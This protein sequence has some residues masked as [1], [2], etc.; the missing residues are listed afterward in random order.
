MLT[1][2]VPVSM[3]P[4]PL[5]RG[6]HDPRGRP[7][8]P[9][10]KT[11]AK[12]TQAPLRTG[13]SKKRLKKLRYCRQRSRKKEDMFHLRRL[14]SGFFFEAV[15]LPLD[16]A[17]FACYVSLL[18]SQ[19]GK[20]SLHSSI[21]EVDDRNID[22]VAFQKA[23]SIDQRLFKKQALVSGHTSSSDIT[24]SDAPSISARTDSTVSSDFSGLPVLPPIR[25][26][27]SPI[28]DVSRETT[29]QLFILP[30][31]SKG[32]AS[33]DVP[34]VNIQPATPQHSTLTASALS[35]HHPTPTADRNE[36][37]LADIH[38][39]LPPV[40]IAKLD[41]AKSKTSRKINKKDALADSLNSG[42]LFQPPPLLKP[43]HAHL[44]AAHFEN[45]HFG[46]YPGHPS[47]SSF[48]DSLDVNSR[49]HWLMMAG[50]QSESLKGS[51]VMAPDGEIVSVGGS[52]VRGGVQG[53][54][55]A[56][57]NDVLLSYR[58]EGVDE[59][60]VSVDETDPL[61]RHSLS[62]SWQSRS[63][64]Q[65]GSL[66]SS[67]VSKEDLGRLSSTGKYLLWDQ[68]SRLSGDSSSQIS[69]VSEKDVMDTLADHA[70]H[71]AENVLSRSGAGSDLESDVK[72]AAELW[73]KMHPK[74]TVLTAL[75]G[76]SVAVDEI[77]RSSGSNSS[78]SSAAE[79]K[80]LIAKSL[81]TAAAKAAGIDPELL[82]SEP[83][84]SPEVLQ[85]LSSQSL[86]PEQIEIVSDDE[87]KLKI[88]VK[89]DLD[90]AMGGVQ[91]GHIHVAPGSGSEDEIGRRHVTIPADRGSQLGDANMDVI[92]YKVPDTLE[93]SKQGVTV[94]QADKSTHGPK[95]VTEE[96]ED[97][98]VGVKGMVPQ[99]DI[100]MVAD[101][102][103]P[104]TSASDSQRVEAKEEKKK[105]LE[106]TYQTSAHKSSLEK[107]PVENVQEN[108][109]WWKMSRDIIEPT[110]LT[111][112]EPILFLLIFILSSADLSVCYICQ[113]VKETSLKVPQKSDILS[114][115]KSK[116]DKKSQEQKEEP[117]VVGK[118]KDKKPK[119]DQ[120]SV[121]KEAAAKR[122]EKKPKKGKKGKKGKKREEELTA[123]QPA[124]AEV[125]PPAIVEEKAPT[126]PPPAAVEPDEEE[127]PISSSPEA[128]SEES[129][130]EFNFIR[131]TTS[132]PPAELPPQPKSAGK[133]SLSGPDESAE[134]DEEDGAAVSN[135]K[136]ISN[137]EARAAKRAAAAA[138]RREEVERRRREKEEQHR[139]EKEEIER[140]IALQ[141]EME[142]EKRRREEE[143]RLQSVT[144]QVK[145]RKAIMSPKISVFILKVGD[146]V[147]VKS[148]YGRARDVCTVCRIRVH[149]WSLTKLL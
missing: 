19:N 101:D 24:D 126:P 21:P 48:V 85:A 31:I 120:T 136:S 34:T 138:K 84:I 89:V 42:I 102:K 71:I 93:D 47:V 36:D 10:H 133:K 27:L 45:F 67:S 146:C 61:K 134:S 75:S 149:V 26:T 77:M 104:V 73:I 114:D 9:Q 69:S 39:D 33:L 83:H 38:V 103:V 18:D 131:E 116:K 7:K 44:D 63:F 60:G 25:H 59:S 148:C 98:N 57:M 1:K 41:A 127:E 87:G 135:L 37:G 119:K 125:A 90:Q 53:N 14:G 145:E 5:I 115:S 142:E 124:P 147:R 91:H 20:F 58:N 79:Y 6:Q 137:K 82:T 72:Q 23:G 94:L 121:K 141:K 65:R 35:H 132:P 62:L 4:P 74:K 80:S 43:I 123:E 15:A 64:R 32:G 110:M 40:G 113:A 3:L 106:N 97:L 78:A 95:S 88:K 2:T 22:M 30:P 29:S 81:T 130:F 28:R 139:R 52:V 109:H 11:I 117:F 49:R 140:Q 107:K 54:D 17:I 13:I 50:G 55:V 56:N 96:T 68:T 99:E 144:P 92:S 51:V 128:Q 122:E 105:I 118:P 12:Q 111:N 16:S 112:I 100:S 70:H 108:V 129:D 86:T 46:H 66:A 143:R 76:G 8:D